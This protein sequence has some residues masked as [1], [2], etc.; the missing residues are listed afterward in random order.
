MRDTPV[1]AAPSIRVATGSHVGQV[2]ANNE[3]RVYADPERGGFA[4]I[5]GVGGQAA[6]EFA[7]EAALDTIHQRLQLQIG[8]PAER[9][10][11]AIALANDQI[12]QQ[13]QVHPDRHGMAC[14]L[15]L[16]L[17]HNGTLTAGHVGDT[18][19]Y[20]MRGGLL[21][22]LT[23]DHSPIGERE[24]R[25][26]LTESEAMRHPRRNEVYREVG[27]E[28]HHPDEEGFI[29]VIEEPFEADAALLLCS[30]GL[31]DVLSSAAISG[32]I[33]R[34]AGDPTQVVDRLIDRANEAGGKDNISVVYIEGAAFAQTLGRSIGPGAPTATVLPFDGSAI[35]ARRT[36]DPGEKEGIWRRLGRV[37][38][39][40]SGG[41][42]PS[43]ADAPNEGVGD[44]SG[45]ATHCDAPR[46]GFAGHAATRA[47]EVTADP[48]AIRANDATVAG[49]RSPH[50]HGSTSADTPSPHAPHSANAG[51]TTRGNAAGYGVAR[52]DAGEPGSAA[53]GLDGRMTG[54]GARDYAGNGPHDADG[55]AGNRPYDVDGRTGNRSHDADTRGVGSLGAESRTAAGPGVARGSTGTRRTG[56][57]TAPAL[58]AA[59]ATTES[60]ADV[61]A[62][63]RGASSAHPAS[64]TLTTSSAQ[65]SSTQPTSATQAR[66][67][68]HSARP[69]AGVGHATAASRVGWFVGGLLVGVAIALG[70]AYAMRDVLIPQMQS[71]TP[72]P[73]TLVVDPSAPAPLAA[74]SASAVPPTTFRTIGHALAAARAGDTIH[75]SAGEYREQII[76]PDGVNLIAR[77]PRNTV[78]RA[79]AEALQPFTAI[80]V[81]GTRHESRVSGFK[82]AGDAQAP[83]TIGVHVLGR[84][85]LDDLDVSGTTLAGIELAGGTMSVTSSALHDNA[86]TGVALK[87]GDARL[88]HNVLMRNGGSMTPQPGADIV[89]SASPQVTFLGN[90]FGADPAQRVRGLGADQIARVKETNIV[91][92]PPASAPAARPRAGGSRR[93]PR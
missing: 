4:V 27:A 5:D 55:R 19:L 57:A 50:A 82:I 69:A 20:K 44:W 35:A 72:G 64:S 76:V 23:H 65:T 9:V 6:G 90:V 86:G 18:R 2:R 85:A 40:A 49:S 3:D 87:G 74:A 46:D 21:R 45:T 56:S 89:A 28:P 10:R 80:I 30:D 58:Q 25:G 11:E 8:T 70:I 31:T 1:V 60:A 47:S 39:G 41:A 22:K 15:T 59:S 32:I 34:H 29:E 91:L 54:A 24:D 7:A 83:I 38:R 93:P 63:T 73:R 16:V 67:S 66:Q 88:A 71:L 13:A 48:A 43:R 53:M 84:A 61:R 12:Y 17:L 81:G 26:E 77:S 52:Q 51:A 92:P 42:S 62:R 33:E 14:V 37:A 79:P 68:T 36:S 78:L 75:V